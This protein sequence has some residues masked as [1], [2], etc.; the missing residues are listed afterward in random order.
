M[1]TLD[2]KTFF[3]TTAPGG[4]KRG[5]LDARTAEILEASSRGYSCSQIA[6]FLK[7][8]GITVTRGAVHKF[9]E[10]KTAA[11]S[12]AAAPGDESGTSQS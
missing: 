4:T 6:E 10:R 9:I 5:Q 12:A 7:Q 1:T 11:A 2:I 3:A 8:N